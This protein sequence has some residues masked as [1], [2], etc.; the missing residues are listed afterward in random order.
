MPETILI[1]D[2]EVDLAETWARL[3]RKAGFTC[4]VACDSGEA[5]SLFDSAQPA[6]V[7][8]DIVLPTADGFEIARCVKRKSPD[9]PIILMTANHI[10]GMEENARKA[11][12]ALYLRK[13]VSNSQLIAS[14]T[15]LVHANSK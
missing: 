1:V 10:P 4:L 12:A 11:G 13:P 2:D 6:L 3:L 14:V 7:L 9:T 15:S 8:S 5:L